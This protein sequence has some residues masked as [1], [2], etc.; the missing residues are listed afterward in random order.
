MLNTLYL[1]TFLA[2]VDAGNY[3]AAAEQLHMSQPA[4]SQHIRAL[5]EQLGDV[6]LFRRSGQRMVPTHAGE[7]LLVTARELVA[8]VERTEQNIRAMRGQTTG[9][10]VIGCTANSG[11][12]LLPPLLAAFRLNHPA[13]TLS[14]RVGNVEMLLNALTE[15]QIDLL[16]LEEQ[17]RRRGWESH[18]LGVEPICLI[19]PVDHP[20]LQS[21]HVP[22][23]IVREYPCTL[24]GAGMPLRRT[25]ED[26]LRRRGIALG[27]I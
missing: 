2:V 6:R 13:V 7:E 12:Y 22:L 14:V 27:P 9:R 19:A 15:R 21:D 4:V 1:Q 8:M 11:E 25:L 10:V 17:Q 24:P 23:S 26:A 20:L 16:V 5:E 3:T 18:M